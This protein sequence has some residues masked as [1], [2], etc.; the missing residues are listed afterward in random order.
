MWWGPGNTTT[1]DIYISKSP[2]TTPAS[3]GSGQSIGYDQPND[4][5]SVFSNTVSSTLP[6][7]VLT[8]AKKS[9]PH[10]Y[11]WTTPRADSSLFRRG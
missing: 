3:C 10:I 2:T 5:S 4:S 8:K 11:F 1:T 6:Q 9:M 7:V